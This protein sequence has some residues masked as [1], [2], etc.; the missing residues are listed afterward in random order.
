M[1]PETEEGHFD[2]VLRPYAEGAGLDVR[3]Y[4]RAT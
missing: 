2:A 3:T 1:P 4:G